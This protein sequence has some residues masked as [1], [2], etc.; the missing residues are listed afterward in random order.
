MPSTALV[1]SIQLAHL[2]PSISIYA[3]LNTFVTNAS[4]IRTQ[5]L[6]SNPDYDFAFIDASSILSTTHILA[7]VFRA[8]NDLL[9]ARLKSRNVHSEIVFS[10]NSSN[11]VCL[12]SSS[13]STAIEMQHSKDAC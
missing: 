3:S 7:A 13:Q 2:P 11:N 6:S 10:L 4:H 5:L 8:V 1:S 12:R 9:N